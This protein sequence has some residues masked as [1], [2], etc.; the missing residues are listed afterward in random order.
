MTIRA[1]A[2]FLGGL[3][4]CC[5]AEAAEPKHLGTFG[6]WSAYQILEKG[7]KACYML[8]F[9]TKEEGNYTKRGR[10][11][12]LVT[13]RPACKALNV[14]SFHAGYGFK[15]GQ[16]V[17]VKIEGRHKK[18]SFTL[19]TEG[20]TAWAAD[21]KTDQ[22]ITTGL[23]QW[24]QKMVVHG[25]S[26]RGTKTTDTYSLKGSLKALQTISRACGVR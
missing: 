2:L 24:G 15:N 9:P 17:T 11:Y 6:N 23:A 13:H 25:R 16:E 22:A 20:E 14:V 26:A 4:V 1:M 10:V 12:M 7:Q 8:S 5:T 21:S 19:F 3:F 18:K